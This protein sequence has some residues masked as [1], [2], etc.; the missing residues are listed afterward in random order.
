MCFLSQEGVGRGGAMSILRTNSLGRLL[1]GFIALGSM[2]HD[3]VDE[4]D[5]MRLLL[6]LV[7]RYLRHG[8]LFVAIDAKSK[9]TMK[10]LV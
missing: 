5:G 8:A 2:A 1:S 3:A 10:S 4:I 6:G 7:V 9:H